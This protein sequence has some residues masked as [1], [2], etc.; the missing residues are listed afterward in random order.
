M[1]TEAEIK[2]AVELRQLSISRCVKEGNINGVFV[3]ALMS[4]FEWTMEIDHED[5]R[6]VETLLAGLARDFPEQTIAAE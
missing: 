3:L 5:A 6:Q 1:K 4:G 2:R